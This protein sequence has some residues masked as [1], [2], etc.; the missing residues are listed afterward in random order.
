MT[1]LRSSK[2]RACAFTLFLSTLPVAGAAQLLEVS[3]LAGSEGGYANGTGAGA[4]F[5]YPMAAVVD[6]LGYVYV[7]DT[8]NHVI[9]LVTPDGVVT[10]LAGAARSSGAEDGVGGSARFNNPYGLALDSTGN[11]FVADTGNGTVRRV[12][13]DGVVTTWAGRAGEFGSVDGFR[14]AARF[15]SPIGI[16]IDDDGNV[17]V[18]D[19]A[20]HTIRRIDAAGE[21]ETLAGLG[22]YPGS[23]DGTGTRAR[24][25]YPFGMVWDAGNLYVTDSENHTVRRVSP[26]GSVTTL[27]GSGGVA[28]SADGSGTAARF[29]QPGG[30]AADAAG[31]LWVVDTGNQLIRRISPEGEVTTA[32]GRAGELG[33]AGGVGSSARFHYPHGIATTPSGDVVIVDTLNHRLRRGTVRNDATEEPPPPPSRTRAARRG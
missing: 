2:F 27:Y 18:A 16:A 6:R 28:G 24:F 1:M 20:N 21:V 31:V 4:S 9:R 10:K 25:F 19:H 33:T 32:A 23:E 17:Y 15:N 11:L 22:G 8:A 29:S 5:F 12:T 26:S 14:T 13:R 7:A 30:I 3:P